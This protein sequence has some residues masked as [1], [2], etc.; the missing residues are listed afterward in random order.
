M[1]KDLF[2]T[3]GKATKPNEKD[4]KRLEVIKTIIEDKELRKSSQKIRKMLNKPPS[5]EAQILAWLRAGKSL[6]PME[7][8]SM[9][10]CWALAQRII[11]IRK[12]GYDIHTEMITTHSGKRIARYTLIQK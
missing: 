2:T 10:N 9:F 5:Q 7:A 12:K 11:N 4:L 1:E 6:T 8:L 3:L